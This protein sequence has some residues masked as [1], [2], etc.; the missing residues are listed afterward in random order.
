MRR[1]IAQCAC[2]LGMTCLLVGGCDKPSDAQ[3]GSA[4]KSTAPENTAAENSAGAAA[5]ESDPGDEIAQRLAARTGLD[6]PPVAPLRPDP[7]GP[8]FDLP[9]AVHDFG[10]VWAGET[11]MESFEFKNIGTE[12]LKILE[13][14]PRCSCSVAA[15]YTKV[16]PPGGTGVI[17]FRLVT[18]NKSGQ[19]NEWL[20][21]KTN[22]PDQPYMQIYMK[23]IVK[24]VCSFEPKNKAA[25]GRITADERLERIIKMKNTT[26]EPL[27]LKLISQPAQSRFRGEF[28][29]LVPG[30]AFELTVIGEPPHPEGRSSGL[31]RFQT[32]IPQKPYIDVVASAYVPSRVEVIPHKV[33]IDPNAFGAME[34]IIRITNNGD[35]PFEITKIETSEPRLNLRM[36]PQEKPGE[37]RVGLTVPGKAYVPPPYGE[38]IRIH[39]TDAEQ[40]LIE[41]DVLPSLQARPGPRPTDDPLI[42][43]PRQM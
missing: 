18:T 27:E 9:K 8:A 31:F 33:V 37:W 35:T 21:I 15:N 22:A 28:R 14:K 23:G 1:H 10:V 40:S 7:G 25:F 12:T 26:G 36:L 41:L 5:A 34:R 4:A 32:N 13:A 3:G 29:E 6:K 20:R 42:M 39:T 2:I 11:L 16:V 19:V 38:L 24:T 17:P 43:H 30:E